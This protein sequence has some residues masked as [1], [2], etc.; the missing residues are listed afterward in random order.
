MEV[1]TK[2]RESES[3]IIN[4]SLGVIISISLLY[5]VNKYSFAE[6]LL[7]KM[8]AKNSKSFENLW[9][10][11][12]KFSEFIIFKEPDLLL[13]F[14]A[15]VL[16]LYGIMNRGKNKLDATPIQANSYLAITGICF[17]FLQFSSIVYWDGM[18]L[19]ILILSFIR[20]AN[21]HQ[22]LLPTP[23]IDQFNEMEQS[24]PQ[25]E[26]LIQTPNSVNLAYDFFWK[27]WKRGFI[28]MLATTRGT[29]VLGTAGSGKTA[30]ILVPAL[31][32]SIYKGQSGVVYDFKYPNM[33]L[34]AFNALVKTLKENPF[35]FGKIDEKTSMIPKF[36][37]V[38]FNDLRRSARVNPIQPKFINSVANAQE[39]AKLLLTNLNRSWIGKESEFFNASAINLVAMAIYFL[40]LYS[41]K[42]KLDYCTLPHVVE[43]VNSNIIDQMNLYESE[44]E[45]RVLRSIFQ[46]AVD[47]KAT[48]QLGGQI[49]SALNSLAPLASKEVY[50]VLSGNDFDLEINNPS[51]PTIL[52]LGTLIKPS[53]NTFYEFANGDFR[54]IFEK[55]GGRA[56]KE[57]DLN[58]FLFIIRPYYRGGEFDFLLNSE[59]EEDL[60]ELPFVIYELDNIKDH[61]ILLPIVTLVITNNY[62]TKLF[63]LKNKLK[64]LI[65]EEAWKAVSND[66]F[67]T[68]LLWA[69]KTA[70]KHFGAIGVISQE[71]DDLLKSN[72]IGEAIIQNTDIK[73]LMD[74]RNYENDIQKVVK[75]FK[76]SEKD[77][78]QIFSINKRPF[79][80]P[81]FNEMAVILGK[82]CKVYGVE[83]SRE[84]YALFT[85]EPSEVDEI[86]AIAERKQI[87]Q[88]DAAIEWA[89]A[90]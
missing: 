67:A 17:I 37:S 51:H 56:E 23:S 65:I 66:F 88:K 32:Q 74:L 41:E 11:K 29:L 14:M 47:A 73:I 64:I 25:T 9:K 49:A 81:K 62:V 30:S 5:L 68:F 57:F 70:R 20:G 52:C 3:R 33:S 89:K 44:P 22:S 28:N 75:S 36:I 84:A 42:N 4:A 58:N 54:A 6:I 53:F 39:I 45:L 86:K 69:F 1:T 77:L 10:I 15:L 82:T 38:N 79:E 55:L 59:K 78:A 40:K 21:L 18:L 61:P 63:G 16:V 8:E 12:V 80:R 50:W 35:A 34:E 71:I 87:S 83:V 27:G 24:F 60:S 85:T 76:V 19:I 90:P 43:L 26:R 46:V 48:D 13:Y 2:E 31:W 72:V 7:R